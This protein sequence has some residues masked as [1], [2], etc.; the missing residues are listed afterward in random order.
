[1]IMEEFFQQFVALADGAKISVL[2]GMIF[3]NLILG[4]A[5]SIYTKTFRL[6]AMADF[7]V[8]RV[9]PYCVGYIAVVIIA[10]VEPAWGVAVPIVW[11]VIIA[12]LIGSILAKLKEMG[13]KLPDV[14][15]GDKK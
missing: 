10:V 15:A 13:I 8:S 9:L 4:L 12:A 14:L 11:A 1:M 2:A 3:A 5:V 6:K 7:M